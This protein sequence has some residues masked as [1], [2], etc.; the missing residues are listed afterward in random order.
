MSRLTDEELKQVWDLRVE[1]PIVKIRNVKNVL[2]DKL[3]RRSIQSCTIESPDELLHV[4]DELKTE[5][6]DFVRE[7]QQIEIPEYPTV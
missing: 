3:K 7:L 5:A 4:I 6:L 2:G 1:A